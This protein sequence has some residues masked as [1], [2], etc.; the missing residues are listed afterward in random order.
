MAKTPAST[1]FAL[2][3]PPLHLRHSSLLVQ[4]LHTLSQMTALPTALERVR[5]VRLLAVLAMPVHQTRHNQ[6]MGEG[7]E[8]A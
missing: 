4:V 2:A 6:L 1:P 5:A 7:L 3:Q 8:Q